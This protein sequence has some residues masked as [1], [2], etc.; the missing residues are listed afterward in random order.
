MEKTPIDIIN[1]VLSFVDFSFCADY[2]LGQIGLNNQIPFLR[3][4][5]ESKILTY[6]YDYD[7]KEYIEKENIHFSSYKILRE[8]LD[9]NWF[10]LIS[11]RYVKNCFYK[12]YVFQADTHYA[13]RPFY[14]SIEYPQIKQIN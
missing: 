3:I 1:V 2:R 13:I 10:F 8:Y 6:Q 14:S 12:M 4:P 7:K 5:K 9:Y 11:I